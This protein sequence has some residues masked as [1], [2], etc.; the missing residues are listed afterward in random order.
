MVDYFFQITTAQGDK[1]TRMVRGTDYE[2]ACAKVNR[3]FP[4]C[5]I[6]N[7]TIEE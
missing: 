5:Y 2:D 3:Q 7:A 1:I 4:D 6:Y